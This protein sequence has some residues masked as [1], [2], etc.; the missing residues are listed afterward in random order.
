MVERA[1]DRKAAQD[2]RLGL[3][4]QEHQLKA[5]A[6]QGAGLSPWEAE[7]LVEVVHEV[8]C[9][10]PS[11]RPLAPGQMR[12]LCV[13]AS[14][15]AG[16]PVEAC[17]T[18]PVVLTMLDREDFTAAGSCRLR[19]H[20]MVRLVQEARDQGGLLSQEDLARLLGCDVRTVRRDVR[21]LRELEG[22][23]LATRGQEKDIGPGVTHRDLVIRLW[24][25][26]HEPLAVARRTDHTLHS[27][28]RYIGHF[29]RVVFLLWKGLNT[30][31]IALAVGISTTST[32]RYVD[33]YH[34]VH[35]VPRYRR[36]L[37]EVE[38][39]AGPY[40]EAEGQKR[41]FSPSGP[42]SAERRPT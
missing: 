15:G 11:E 14:E 12:Y 32:Q 23:H 26:G 22:L 20:R 19:Q 2:R 37:Q 36:R 39:I 30:F 16:K 38:V 31:Q 17:Q 24:L 21:E 28:E 25:E 4:T 42:G 7:V 13:S 40:D 10:D 9:G 5:L 35:R 34:Q 33:L 3:K 29:C 27:V 1:A 8:L 18:T 6:I 41:G